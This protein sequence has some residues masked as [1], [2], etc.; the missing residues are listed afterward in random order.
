MIGFDR[1]AGTPSEAAQGPDPR[2]ATPAAAVIGGNGK[3]PARL[4]EYVFLHQA[5]PES[6]PVNAMAGAT[7][8]PE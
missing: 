4:S 5:R 1:V 7:T 2:S 3:L 8:C 6:V